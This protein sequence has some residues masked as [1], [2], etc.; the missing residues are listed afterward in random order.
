M[1]GEYEL[2]KAK[3]PFD[4]KPWSEFIDT[5]NRK[6]TEH[7]L[8]QNPDPDSEWW[9]SFSEEEHKRVHHT[10]GNLILTYNNSS[11]WN[12]EYAQPDN[13]ALQQANAEVAS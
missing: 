2:S 5:G 9:N 10:L 6:T 7:V 11:Y 8:P 12:K 3:S 4:V 13:V 1:P